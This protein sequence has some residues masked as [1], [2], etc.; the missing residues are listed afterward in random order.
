MTMKQGDIVYPIFREC[1]LQ[2]SLLRLEDKHARNKKIVV[3]IFK[4]F[5]RCLERNMIVSGIDQR[6][7]LSVLVRE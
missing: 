4:A 5:L 7:T 2:R 6:Y 3:S 1:A